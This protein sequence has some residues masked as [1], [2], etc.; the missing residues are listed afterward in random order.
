MSHSARAPAWVMST[1][2]VL[3]SQTSSPVRSEE[4]D[5]SIDLFWR[6]G[7]SAAAPAYTLAPFDRYFGAPRLGDDA[8]MRW[9]LPVGRS[10]WAIAAGYLGLF[11]LLLV[12]GPFAIGAGVLGLRQI[13]ANPRMHGKGRA[14]FGIVAGA[15]ATVLLVLIL[16]GR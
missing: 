9:L 8:A 3:C 6:N 10:P 5:T 4:W 13:S 7:M 1:G 15:L 2:A 11:S 16:A 12:F 14:V